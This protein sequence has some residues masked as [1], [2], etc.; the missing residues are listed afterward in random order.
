MTIKGVLL[1]EHQEGQCRA[2]VGHHH[3]GIAVYCAQPVVEGVNKLPT[4]WC[5][6]H[7][8]RYMVRR[9]ERSSNFDDRKP[10]K[11]VMTEADV[12]ALTSASC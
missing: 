5:Q 3:T 9:G 7:Y 8:K 6:C 11:F 4:S 10:F 2:I 1:T 12:A